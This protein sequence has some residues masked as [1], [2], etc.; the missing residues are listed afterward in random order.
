MS[1]KALMVYALPPRDWFFAMTVRATDWIAATQDSKEQEE[2]DGDSSSQRYQRALRA[3][4]RHPFFE[5]DGLTDARVV[6]RVEHDD[7]DFLFRISNN[8]IT[9]IVT[10]YPFACPTTASLPLGWDDEPL[11]VRDKDV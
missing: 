8:G 10:G 7:L 2:R 3:V 4:M 9:F 6:Y 1:G 11:T 5:R